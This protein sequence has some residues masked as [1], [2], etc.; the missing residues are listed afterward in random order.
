MSDDPNRFEKRTATIDEEDAAQADL[1][2]ERL[3]AALLDTAGLDTLPEPEPLIHGVL[4]RDSLAWLAGR[5][6]S[7]KTFVAL[8]MAGAVGAGETW[9]GY[10]VTQGPVLYLIAEGAR[11]IR[12]RVRAWESASGRKMTGVTFLPLAVKASTAEWRA[13]CRIA[14]ESRPALVVIDTQARVTLGLEENSAKDMGLFI[15]ELESLRCSCSACVLVLHHTP[16]NGDNLRGSTAMEG[17]ATTIIR[18]EKEG[19]SITLINDPERGGK[20]KD[21]DTF[22]DISLRLIP[23][24]SSAVLA[25]TDRPH[26][27]HTDSKAVQTMLSRWWEF[28]E[29]DEV[30]VAVLIKSGACT[31]ATFHRHKKA[32][33]KAGLI[34]KSGKGNNVR[35]RLVAEPPS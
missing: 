6:G 26:A 16:R 3:R 32:L 14:K 29:S 5:P 21:S 34:V 9:Q 20:Q 35:Y 15:D 2:Y 27:T 30:S 31:E 8:D 22:D 10:R 24:E 25:L 12:P 11:G 4:Q 23:T 28:H 7:A 1:P 13:L 33:D 18:V 19:T 17:A